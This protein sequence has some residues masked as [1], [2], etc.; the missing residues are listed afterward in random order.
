MTTEQTLYKGPGPTRAAKPPLPLFAQAF[1]V[2][3]ALTQIRPWR[4]ASRFFTWNEG[5]GQTQA[6]IN[7]MFM[8]NQCFLPY[9]LSGMQPFVEC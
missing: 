2:A 4:F 6:E 9:D 8:K 1:A 7:L 5:G 3:S